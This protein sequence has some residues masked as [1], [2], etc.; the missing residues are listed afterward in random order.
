MDETAQLQMT[1]AGMAYGQPS[2]IPGYLATHPLT[3]RDWSIFWIAADVDV[4]LAFA[5]IAKNGRTG[6]YAVAIRGTYPNPL[7]PAYWDDANFDNPTGT[8]HP[9]SFGNDSSAKVSAGTWAAFQAV[10]ALSDGTLSFAQVLGG[11]P[12]DA[13]VQVTGH[14]LGGTLAPVLALWLSTQPNQVLADVYAFAGMTPGNRAFANLFAAASPLA[15]RVRRY[16]N[17][18]DTVPYGWDRVWATRNFYSP[19]PSGGLI[20][21]ILIAFMALRLKFY[22]FAAIGGEHVLHGSIQQPGVK[23]ELIA[24]VLENLRQH[25]PATYL[26]LL[27]APPLPFTLDFGSVVAPRASGHPSN[28]LSGRLRTIYL[29]QTN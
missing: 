28:L 13:Q 10:L 14:S 15:N 29:R 6:G 17:D 16:N 18:L 26:E 1:L 8:M 7:S 21:K 11:I 27:G 22:G 23:Y 2:D 5:F 3:S 20:V 12:R 9:W 19:H 24:Y 4:P 25:M